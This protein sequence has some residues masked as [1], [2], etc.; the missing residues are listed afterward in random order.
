MGLSSLADLETRIDGAPEGLHLAPRSIDDVSRILRTAGESGTPVRVWG[1]GTRQKMGNPPPDGLVVSMAG[2]GE[3]IA[4][5]PD[6]LTVV[7]GAGITVADLEDR[8]GAKSQTA[9]LPERPGA[10]TLGG[11]LATGRA[12]LRRARLLAPRE[13]VLEMTTVTGDG[14]V[15]R[16]G[17]RVVKNV[18]GFDLH[19]A[20]VGAFGSLGVIVQV[21]LK[22]WPVPRSAATVRIPEADMARVVNR[23][24]AVLESGSGVDVMVWGTEE[25]VAATVERLDGDARPGLEW[26]EDPRGDYLWSLRVPPALTG[27]AVTR[28]GPWDFL[29]IHGAG[30]IRLASPG[31][32]EADALRAWAEGE[33]GSLVLVDHPGEMPPMDPWGAVPATVDIQRRL[34][35]EFDPL[36]TINPNRLP[37]GL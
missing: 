1:G 17:G 30:E 36:R 7:A 35:A 16:S 19:R 22:L 13:R 25:D 24:L 23:P 4:W 32:E 27:D 33:G 11:V 12:P 15:V 28:V 31:Y 20:S 14:R 2:I 18:S 34:I 21:C 26:P 3:I 6:D 5:E 9:V 10:S 37:G 29:A 8:L